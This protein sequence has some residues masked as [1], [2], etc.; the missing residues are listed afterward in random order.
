[1]RVV[2]TVNC[3]AWCHA[4]DDPRLGAIQLHP[5]DDDMPVV[6]QWCG[7]QASRGNYLLSQSV[8]FGERVWE[9]RLE[10]K[11]S[12]QQPGGGADTRIVQVS[13]DTR[14]VGLAFFHDGSGFDYRI[15]A[16]L[17]TPHYEGS[18]VSIGP[19]QLS[20]PIIEA[21][22]PGRLFRLDGAKVTPTERL[23]QGIVSANQGGMMNRT[24]PMLSTIFAA[25]RAGRSAYVYWGRNSHCAADFCDLYDIEG[26]NF[27]EVD[28]S[29]L[30]GTSEPCDRYDETKPPAPLTSE[31]VLLYAV[32]PYATQAS[33]RPTFPELSDVYRRL[34]LASAIRD[35]IASFDEIDFS[36]TVGFHVRRAYPNGAF[37]ALESEKFGVDEEVFIVLLK[38]IRD[39]FPEFKNAFVC[40]NDLALEARIKD[41]LGDYILSFSKTTV[42]NT[43]DVVAVQ[44]AMVDLNLMGRCPVIFS[45]HATS[46]GHFAHI[47][48]GNLLFT[49]VTD[50]QPVGSRYY[51]W[52]EGRHIETF[53]V[54]TDNLQAMRDRMAIATR[55]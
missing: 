53:D 13:F 55:R 10:I 18:G 54:S 45:Q 39:E 44:E 12:I 36:R 21:E 51:T 33:P 3:N 31:N 50:H 24:H 28:P 32:S 1:M 48:G 5:N 52:C 8:G 19:I 23:P 26:T 49:M 16:R 9:G 11:I 20:N 17:L 14:T 2:E 25:E 29:M 34:K 40:T 35:M 27:E 6:M 15:E 47:L 46:F 4:P 42:D 43:Q 7:L 37:S 41:Q 22:H 38:K 30:A